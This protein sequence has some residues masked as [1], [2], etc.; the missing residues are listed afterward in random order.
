[1][2]EQDG[3]VGEDHEVCETFTPAGVVVETHDKH[4]VGD[5][6]AGAVHKMTSDPEANLLAVRLRYLWHHDRVEADGVDDDS[7]EN[8]IRKVSYEDFDVEVFT[9]HTRL[10]QQRVFQKVRATLSISLILLISIYRS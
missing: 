9:V 8:G 3:K 4:R 5:Q 10:V 6:D 1:M 2:N 7:V